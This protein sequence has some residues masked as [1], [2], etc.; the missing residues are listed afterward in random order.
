MFCI[1]LAK[2]EILDVVFNLTEGFFIVNMQTN[3]T[4][5]ENTLNQT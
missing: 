2:G 4:F 3:Q 1:V 5:G